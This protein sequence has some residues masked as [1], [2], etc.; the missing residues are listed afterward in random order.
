MK[1]AASLH[2]TRGPASA[3]KACDSDHVDSVSST[4]KSQI[5]VPNKTGVPVVTAKLSSTRPIAVARGNSADT[6]ASLDKHQAARPAQLGAK[7]DSQLSE[8]S[9]FP[10]S[11][12]AVRLQEAED[13]GIGKH[14]PPPRSDPP[15]HRRNTTPAHMSS[16]STQNSVGRKS[17]GSAGLVLGTESG[18][19]E[20]GGRVRALSVDS[21]LCGTGCFEAERNDDG[22]EGMVADAR[23]SFVVYALL[24]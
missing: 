6:S 22:L 13:D 24:V 18:D 9:A 15:S 5:S 3:E 8:V 16:A 14:T 20:S 19:G 11:P 12:P 1:A 10:A 23:V 4:G 7:A 21:H 2:D 17:L